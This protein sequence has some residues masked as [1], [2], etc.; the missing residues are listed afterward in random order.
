MAMPKDFNRV[1]LMTP[2]R[3]RNRC[4][5]S[6]EL[7]SLKMERCAVAVWQAFGANRDGVLIVLSHRDA[8]SSAFRLVPINRRQFATRFAARAA[9]HEWNEFLHNLERFHGALAYQSPVDFETQLN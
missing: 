4:V 3:C 5:V 1:E 6:K 8:G 9:I 2:E 7:R